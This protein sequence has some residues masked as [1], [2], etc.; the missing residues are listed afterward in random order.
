MVCRKRLRYRDPLSLLFFVLVVD[1]PSILIRRTRDEALVTS[2]P[3][4]NNYRCINLQ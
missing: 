1:A 3:S 4:A 2:L